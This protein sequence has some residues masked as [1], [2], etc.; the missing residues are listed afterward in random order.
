METMSDVLWKI[1][2]N[3]NVYDVGLKKAYAKTKSW[4]KS[5]AIFSKDVR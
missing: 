1:K 3:G 5:I 4:R 2:I